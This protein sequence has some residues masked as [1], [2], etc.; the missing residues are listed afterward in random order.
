V[1]TSRQVNGSPSTT[2]SGMAAYSKLNVV[3]AAPSSPEGWTTK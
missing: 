1:A 3:D 2:S